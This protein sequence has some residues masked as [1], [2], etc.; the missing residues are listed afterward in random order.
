MF[1]SVR[2]R[3]A[4]CV[5]CFVSVSDFSAVAEKLLMKKK[6][7]K[8]ELQLYFVVFLF[9]VHRYLFTNGSSVAAKLHAKYGHK[10]GIDFRESFVIAMD[11]EVTVIFIFLICPIF[12]APTR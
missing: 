2:R 3:V 11:F 4:F 5:F 10:Y 12:R 6:D 9:V 1:V 7:D 8:T